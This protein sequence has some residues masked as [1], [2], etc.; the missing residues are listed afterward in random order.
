M[1]ALPLLRKKLGN[2][3]TALEYVDG[4]TYNVASKHLNI[5]LMNVEPEQHLL[6]VE[7]TSQD[8]EGILDILPEFSEALMSQSEQ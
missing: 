7:T 5:E 4:P 3:L 1:E 8:I 2:E 6:F